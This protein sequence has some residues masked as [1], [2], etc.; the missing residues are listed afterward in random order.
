MGPQGSEK[1][2]GYQ[3]IYTYDREHVNFIGQVKS[4]YRLK[5]FVQYIY[6]FCGNIKLVQ[7]VCT[8]FEQKQAYGRPQNIEPGDS[9][10]SCAE[11]SDFDTG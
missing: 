9:N 3:Y 6:F 11:S 5:C 7:R 1:K 10:R 8:S 4:F 2:N